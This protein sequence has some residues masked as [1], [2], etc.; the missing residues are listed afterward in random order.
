VREL[1]EAHGARAALVEDVIGRHFAAERQAAPLLRDCLA[2]PAQRDLFL[3][4]RVARGAV[5]VRLIREADVVERRHA[6][7]LPS[8]M[9][10]L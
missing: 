6:A 2:V 3:E 7:V 10:N 5:F 4:Q 8:S 9:D 1:R